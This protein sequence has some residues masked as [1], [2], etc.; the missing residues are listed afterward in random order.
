MRVLACA[1][2][3]NDRRGPT[4]RPHKAVQPLP[5]PCRPRSSHP[6]AAR[7]TSRDRCDRSARAEVLRRFAELNRQ[8]YEEEQTSAP[9]VK[10]RASNGRVKAAPAGQASLALL[11][12]SEPPPKTPKTKA[13]AHAKKAV[14]GR[15]SK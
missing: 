12:A 4:R 1:S 11:D 9:A 8:R 14:T 6:A 15:A 3:V 2:R 5:R 7:D 10:L 13:A